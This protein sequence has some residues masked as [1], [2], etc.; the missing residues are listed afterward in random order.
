MTAT[1]AM[2][3]TVMAAGADVSWAMPP[4]SAAPTPCIVSI[5]D[6]CRPRACP[7]SSSG[8]RAISCSWSSR[9]AENPTEASVTAVSARG[10]SGRS[11]KTRYGTASSSRSGAPSRS[12]HRRD[13]NRPVSTSPASI[14]N[15]AKANSNPARSGANG[16]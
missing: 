3:S 16:T 10:S 9:L 5:P 6:V 4:A 11:A 8:V 15:A 2:A 1:D 7:L 14:P 13:R 12:R